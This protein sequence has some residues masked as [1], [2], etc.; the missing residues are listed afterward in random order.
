MVF[1]T[2]KRK[3]A[4][5]FRGYR[6][7]S[8]GFK[9]KARGSGHR[10]GVGMAGTGKRG[11]AKKTL[12]INLFGNDYFGKDKA[13]RR[14]N[15]PAKLQVIDVQRIAENIQS[16]VEQG[17]A[18]DNK[19]TYELNLK[20]YKILGDG[21]IKIKAVIQASA[22]SQSAMDKV[23]NA[24]GQII[25]AIRPGKKESKNPAAKPAAAKPAAPA[26]KVSAVKKEEKKAEVKP[27]AVPVAKE[28]KPVKK[29]AKK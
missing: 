15:K 1:R 3:K 29:D 14:G 5:R 22:A 11:D 25:V 21:D 23:K 2:K 8:R 12:I 13:L 28:V 10:G 16:F 17:K 9:K 4:T 24:G 27:A 26:V 18:K 20:G 6:S 7:H 19:G